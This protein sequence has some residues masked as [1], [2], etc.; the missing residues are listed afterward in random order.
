M[1]AVDQQL[2]PPITSVNHSRP[3]PVEGSTV[4]VQ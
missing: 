3:A 1:S 4:G 2:I